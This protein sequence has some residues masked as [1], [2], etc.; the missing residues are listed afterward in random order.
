[1]DYLD[2]RE[3]IILH[4]EELFEMLVKPMEVVVRE[5]GYNAYATALA[6][7]K[8]IGEIIS[9]FPEVKARNSMFVRESF[10]IFKENYIKEYG[11]PEWERIYR[12]MK[13]SFSWWLQYHQDSH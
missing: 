5:K 10:L 1:M 8:I 4:G 11:Q 7:G 13:I 2:D 9:E 3:F 12:V 6:N